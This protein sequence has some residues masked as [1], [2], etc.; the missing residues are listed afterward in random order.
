MTKAA[1]DYSEEAGEGLENIDA[2]DLGTPFLALLQSNSPQL[3]KS[4]DKY[5]KGAG[6]GDIIDSVRNAV[7]YN[8]DA[9][10]DFIPCHT[11]KRYVEWKPRDTGGGFVMAHP[12][13]PED[14]NRDE[15]GKTRLSNGNTVEETM[16]YAGLYMNDG[17]W[18]RA[19]IGMK[20]TQLKK[21]RQWL[22]MMTSL[23]MDGKGGKKFTPPCYSHVYTLATV[24]ESNS[25]GDFY[26]WSIAIKETVDDAALVAQCRDNRQMLLNAPAH[27]ALPAAPDD[28]IKEDVEAMAVDKDG[29]P[30]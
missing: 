25:K 12:T 10:L 23:K 6:Q 17:D 27:K 8:G 7:V 5:I 19:V 21:S 20:S 30:F 24:S 11:E 2:N 16:Y 18:C 4:H 9:G 1:Y 26:N 15:D 14:A 3:N 13:M 29:L 22:N 28:D